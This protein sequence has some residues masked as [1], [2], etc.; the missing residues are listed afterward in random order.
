ME[1]GVGPLQTIT[2]PSELARK[3]PSAHPQ[4]EFAEAL[5]SP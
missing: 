5:G 4:Y 1:A 2:T 3:Q